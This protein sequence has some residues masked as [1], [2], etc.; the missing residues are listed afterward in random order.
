[1]ASFFELNQQEYNKIISLYEDANVL[2][3]DLYNEIISCTNDEIII[4]SNNIKI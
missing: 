4:K 3:Q 1:M 2:N